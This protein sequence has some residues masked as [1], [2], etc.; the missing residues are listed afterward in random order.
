MRMLP[1]EVL[2]ALTL[3]AAAALNR[4]DRLGSLAVGKQAD[5]VVCSVEDYRDLFYHYGF[6]PVWRVYKRGRLVHTA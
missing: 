1:A 5:F 2:N 3:N 6:N 4:G